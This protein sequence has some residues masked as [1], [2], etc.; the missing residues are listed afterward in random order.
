MSFGVVLAF[1][2]AS[3]GRGARGEGLC[4]ERLLQ[5]SPA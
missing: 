1:L 5:T 4:G 3:S 2:K